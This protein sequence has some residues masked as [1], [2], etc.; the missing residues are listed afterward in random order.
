MDTANNVLPSAKPLNFCLGNTV[1]MVVWSYFVDFQQSSH[2]LRSN[3]I[4]KK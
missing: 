3:R 2:Q 1:F 4:L